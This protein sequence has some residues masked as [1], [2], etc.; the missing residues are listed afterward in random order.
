MGNATNQEKDG[1]ARSL[2]RGIKDNFGRFLKG[3]E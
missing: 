3:P 2:L 1:V